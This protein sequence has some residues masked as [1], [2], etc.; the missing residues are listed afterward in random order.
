MK[1]YFLATRDYKHKP[2]NMSKV[3]KNDTVKV[4][5]TGKLVSGEEF[6]S[7]KGQDPLEFTVGSGQIIPGF[8]A[9]VEGMEVN[10]KKTITIAPDQA[11]GPVQDQLISNIERSQLPED[12]TPEVGQMLV[13]TAPDGRQTRVQVTAVQEDTV[14]L[15]ANHP[16]AGKELVF[17]IELV[18][19]VG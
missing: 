15:D 4:H 3:K 9:A 8:D 19:I 17:D 2:N 1:L 7:S 12:I 16:L 13:A 11:Y 14:T 18:E 10:E 5:Y 6:D